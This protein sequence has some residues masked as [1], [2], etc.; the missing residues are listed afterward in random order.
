MATDD[1]LVHGLAGSGDFTIGLH[2]TLVLY[3]SVKLLKFSLIWIA[4]RV[5]YF[6]GLLTSLLRNTALRDPSRKEGSMEFGNF[7]YL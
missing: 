4:S 1:S 3:H 5:Q 6:S 7:K 2:S